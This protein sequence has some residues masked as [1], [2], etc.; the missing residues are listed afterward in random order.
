M[1]A[2]PTA[3]P[4]DI[5]LEAVRGVAA[6]T[7]VLWHNML[8]FFPVISGNFADMGYGLAGQPW[9]GLLNGLGAVNLFFVLSGY[10]LTRAFFL[11]GDTSIITRSAMKR[12][13]RLAGPVLIAIL[14]SYCLWKLGLYHYDQAAALTH[15]P[16]LAGHLFT[17]QPVIASS[18]F[19]DA[20]AQG[21]FFTFVKP[22]SAYFDTV[23]WTM[24]WEFAGSFAAFGLALLARPLEP[25]LRLF[26]FGVAMVLA[27]YW[28]PQ[29][30]PFVLGV[31]L[32]GLLASGAPKPRPA[33][34]IGG[35]VAGVYLLGYGPQPAGAYLWLHRALGPSVVTTYVQ[36]V[37][38]ALI[39]AAVELSGSAR[40]L[41]SGKIPAFLGKLSFPLYLVHIPVLCSFGSMA[42]VASGHAKVGVLVTL[43][44]SF[45]AALPL[46]AFNEYW[47]GLLNRH[48]ARSRRSSAM[49]AA[50]EETAT[51]SV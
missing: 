30:A 7:V 21:L 11:S 50:A 37:G 33:L 42:V 41:L 51:A 4:K 40:G 15:S 16:W 39:I 17:G 28:A 35:I 22:D 32:A 45:L 48:Y 12:W 9:F 24:R 26:V 13:P 46:M 44:V 14:A 5:P 1:E 36:G 34:A 10:V 25:R 2:T 18:K 49:P 31:A 19:L 47:V 29:M 3:R 6:V 27:L 8:G 20:L 38:G 23:L 43:A